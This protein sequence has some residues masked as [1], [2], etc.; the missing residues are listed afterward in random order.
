MEW[1][2]GLGTTPFPRADPEI[3]SLLTEIYR[4]GT[5]HAADGTEIKFGTGGATPALASEL[6]R[7]VRAHRLRRTLEVG[8]GWGLSG[9]AICQ[10]LRDN[11]GGHHVA[12]DPGQTTIYRSVGLLNL[13][14]AG[15]GDL[16]QLFEEKAEFALPDLLRRGEWFDLTFI[17]GWHLHD[18]VMLDLFYARQLVRA[19]GWICLDDTWMPAVSR[20]VAFALRNLSMLALVERNDN[21]CLLRKL[22]RPDDRAWDHFEEF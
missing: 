5:V 18:Y 13:R 14:R 17:D 19:G 12:V 20:T 8:M 16:V 3:N 4:T 22:N 2:Q 11:G 15:L 9:L 7:L 21:Y 10:G 6:Y 1:R